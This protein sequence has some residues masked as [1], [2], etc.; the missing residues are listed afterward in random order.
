MY[1]NWDDA[2]FEIVK[3]LNTL[4]ASPGNSVLELIYT[5]FIDGG[6]VF[7]DPYLRVGNLR[8]QLSFYQSYLESKSTKSLS[9]RLAADIPFWKKKAETTRD[10]LYVGRS[11]G[12]INFQGLVVSRKLV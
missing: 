11:F 5:Y 10:Y 7:S 8:K 6:F 2:K 3:R 4:E 12:E 9:Q 1:E